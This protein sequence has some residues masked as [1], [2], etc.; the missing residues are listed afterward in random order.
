MKNVNHFAILEIGKDNA[1]SQR[2]HC[3]VAG[4]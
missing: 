2:Y 4:Q 3:P 1:D